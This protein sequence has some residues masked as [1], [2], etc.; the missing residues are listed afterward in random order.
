M[1]YW[2][3]IISLKVLKSTFFTYRKRGGKMNISTTI[4]LC[5]SIAIIF[6]T[7]GWIIGRLD[8]ITSDVKTFEYDKLKQKYDELKNS[9]E[10]INKENEKWKERCKN[11]WNRYNL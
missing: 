1:G 5:I 4:M 11:E 7:I 2:T 10:I 8:S 9:I 6:G 3:Y